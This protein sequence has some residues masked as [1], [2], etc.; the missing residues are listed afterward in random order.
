MAGGEEL[1]APGLTRRLIA[2]LAAP[3]PLTV[4]ENVFSGLT[5]RERE[6]VALVAEGLSNGEITRRLVISPAVTKIHISRALTKL[7]VRDRAHLVS[8]AYRHGLVRPDPP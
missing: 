2:K 1:L 6:V 3:P 4:D 5:A 8:L 7:G